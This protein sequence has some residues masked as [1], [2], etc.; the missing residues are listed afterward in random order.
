MN[1]KEIETM[2]KGKL[3]YCDDC[4][5]AFDRYSTHSEPSEWYG[6][7][8]LCGSAG[9]QLRSTNRE[10]SC[11]NGGECHRDPRRPC[12]HKHNAGNCRQGR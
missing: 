8:P 6:S 5:H 3:Y 1:L 11:K 2:P 4:R 10:R 7:C 9:R 12:F